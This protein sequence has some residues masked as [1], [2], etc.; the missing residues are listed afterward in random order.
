MV[1]VPPDVPEQL[2]TVYGASDDIKGKVNIQVKEGRLLDHDGISLELIGRTEVIENP[3]VADWKNITNFVRV[4][5]DVQAAGRLEPGSH[6]IEF[7]FSNVVKEHESYYGRYG[8]CE[9]ERARVLFPGIFR[10][11]SAY[12]G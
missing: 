7:D 5:R 2:C 12:G 9:E 11:A 3:E 1:V 10:H 6:A 4:T 8:L